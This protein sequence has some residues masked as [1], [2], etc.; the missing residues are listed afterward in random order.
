MTICQQVQTG[1]GRPS[2]LGASVN[3]VIDSCALNLGQPSPPKSDS[4]LIA[5]AK[6]WANATAQLISFTPFLL[7]GLLLAAAGLKIQ[8]QFEP[9]LPVDGFLSS[10]WF[11]VGL[12]CVEL[13]LGWSLILG[14]KQS[15]TRRLSLMLFAVFLLY[16]LSQFA[17]GAKSCACLGKLE[18]A[19]LNMAGFDSVVLG[20]LWAWRPRGVLQSAMP[21]WKRIALTG[22]ILVA[23]ISLWLGTQQKAGE[24]V[25]VEPAVID[26]GTIPQG[27][28]RQFAVLLRNERHESVVISNLDT[29]CPC[30][31]CASLPLELAPRQQIG[32]TFD[33]DLANERD[34]TGKLVLEIRG[35]AASGQSAFTAKVTASIDALPTVLVGGS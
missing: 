15:L 29:S 3:Q 34:F 33:F 31:R 23:V 4:V 19:P 5:F 18:M 7:G 16:S 28:R 13:F 22:L 25:T 26:L 21:F 14:L 2:L 30:V 27:Q 12:I 24:L 10:R 11:V 1:T 32:T 35:I 17:F 6:R 9:V 20:A 8:Q